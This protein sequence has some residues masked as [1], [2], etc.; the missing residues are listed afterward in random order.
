MAED[1]LVRRIDLARG[2]LIGG[3]ASCQEYL[4]KELRRPLEERVAL[5]QGVE[6]R[7][8]TVNE[9]F[10][11]IG[12]SLIRALK[13]FQPSSSESGFDFALPADFEFYAWPGYE[14]VTS[15]DSVRRLTLLRSTPGGKKVECGCGR[16]IG[17][18]AAYRDAATA[19]WFSNALAYHEA[20]ETQT[21]RAF[22]PGGTHPWTVAIA[23]KLKT[24]L[25]TTVPRHPAF[26]EPEQTQHLSVLEIGV[27]TFPHDL[28]SV[29]LESH[30]WREWP[31]IISKTL[32]DSLN[33]VGLTGSENVCWPLPVIEDADSLTQDQRNAVESIRLSLYSVWLAATFGPPDI[34]KFRRLLREV[35]QQL[36]DA[37]A[38][39]LPYN[40]Q[41]VHDR[42]DPDDPDLTTTA[43]EDHIFKFWYTLPL[44]TSIGRDG[45]PAP[46]GTFM[47]LTTDRLPR[48]VLYMISSWVLRIYMNLRQYELLTELERATQRAAKKTKRDQFAHLVQDYLNTISPALAQIAHDTPEKK[49]AMAS[50]RQLQFS[51]NLFSKVRGLRKCSEHSIGVID[52]TTCVDDATGFALQRLKKRCAT[53]NNKLFDSELCGLVSD[54]ESLNRAIKDCVTQKLEGLS[55]WISN[56]ADFLNEVGCSTLAQ[57]LCRVPLVWDD[58]AEEGV[59]TYLLTQSLFHAAVFACAAEFVTD[60]FPDLV[61]EFAKPFV[62]VHANEEVSV[63]EF[64]NRV[65]VPVKNFD[66]TIDHETIVNICAKF[67]GAESGWLKVEIVTTDGPERWFT[68]TLRRRHG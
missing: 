8:Q 68:I 36:N 53:G 23:D 18:D 42:L 47:L 7:A 4:R 37:M 12:S 55:G 50:V 56:E 43:C 65:F 64:S 51:A 63:V 2:P 28:F 32:T 33:K 52:W 13:C 1:E 35:R 27:D 16:N 25:T 10:E 41:A 40:L 44:E 17:T 29:P 15:L 11:I 61:F 57:R 62:R 45:Q 66:S 59:F 31:R 14:T 39:D 46:L 19:R 34:R 3:F 26:P 5:W 6:A 20:D 49:A 24:R 54:P 38:L 22:P 30:A 21:L 9:L 60:Y 58:G 48:P 67:D